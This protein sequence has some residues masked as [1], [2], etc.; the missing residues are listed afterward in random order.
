M[1][2]ALKPF[3]FLS[4]VAFRSVFLVACHS[5]VSDKGAEAIKIVEI[6]KKKNILQIKLDH[7]L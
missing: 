7:S 6:K 3:Y 2:Q 4:L 5:L 1:L